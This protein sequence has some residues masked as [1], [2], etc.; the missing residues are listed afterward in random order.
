MLAPYWLS[1]DEVGTRWAPNEAVS[2][3][4]ARFPV[5]VLQ[6]ARAHFRQHI[7]IV[8]VPRQNNSA[9]AADPYFYIPVDGYIRPNNIYRAAAVPDRDGYY[10]VRTFKDVWEWYAVNWA[11]VCGAEAALNEAQAQAA[12][13]TAAAARLTAEKDALMNEI[14]ALRTAGQELSRVRDSERAAAAA[15][16]QA[17]MARAERLANDNNALLARLRAAEESARNTLSDL[18]GPAAGAAD[19]QA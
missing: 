18:L 12:A 11:K 5:E 10:I 17:E 7:L 13:A 4:M 14:N 15:Q 6:R 1:P 9:R 3:D 19:G 8:L 2:T 16:V